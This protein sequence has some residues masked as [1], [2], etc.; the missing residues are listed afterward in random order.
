MGLT[1]EKDFF[2]VTRTSNLLIRGG[3]NYSYDQVSTELHKFLV[4][5]YHLAD[6]SVA[7]AAV[8]LRVTSEHEDECLVTIELKEAEA[9]AAK[10][11]IGSTFI[12]EARK[13]VTKGA[14]P[15]RVRF[16]DIP[17]NFKGDINWRGLEA[18]WK[19]ATATS[20]N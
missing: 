1:G 9:Q 10:D 7:V 2:W 8:G 19:E 20:T 15:D 17:R 6:T 16:A 5:H 4:S 3:A 14:K 18:S 13:T 12:S 11:K